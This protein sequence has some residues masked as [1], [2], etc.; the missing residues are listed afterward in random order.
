MEENIEGV[1][2]LLRQRNTNIGEHV[3]HTLDAN[4]FNF[5]VKLTNGRIMVLLEATQD[6]PLVLESSMQSMLSTFRQE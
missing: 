5:A 1:L 6:F 4:N 3:T 2:A